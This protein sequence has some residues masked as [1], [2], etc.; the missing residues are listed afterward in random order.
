MKRP[1][2]PKSTQRQLDALRASN[3]SKRQRSEAAVQSALT[4][5]VAAGTLVSVAA[6]ARYS[7]V[8]RSFIYSV[9]ELVEAIAACSRMLT[10]QR[11]RLRQTDRP[12]SEESTRN[13]LAD[14]LAEI[15]R[16]RDENSALIAQVGHLIDEIVRLQ[17]PDRPRNVDATDPAF[18]QLSVR[19]QLA[20]K[21]KSRTG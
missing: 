6:V 4:D 13:R 10:D 1:W 9:P 12:A 5:M 21:R 20:Q 8:S 2:M 18:N 11:S 14:A 15:K 7:G 17:G 16:M 19:A 3:H